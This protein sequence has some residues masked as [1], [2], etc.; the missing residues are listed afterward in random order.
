MKIKVGHREFELHPLL[1][2]SPEIS[3]VKKGPKGLRMNESFLDSWRCDPPARWEGFYHP[4]LIRHHMRTRHWPTEKALKHWKKQYKYNRYINSKFLEVSKLKSMR[5]FKTE[6]S[7]R[8]PN[9][10]SKVPWDHLTAD[11]REAHSFTFT[12]RE[13]HIRFYIDIP[14]LG[15]LIPHRLFIQY[16][17]AVTYTARV[18]GHCGDAREFRVGGGKTTT[19]E[20]TKPDSAKEVMDAWAE[21]VK[22]LKEDTKKIKPKMP[23]KDAVKPED[24]QK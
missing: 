21:G 9:W 5:E 10:T 13:R 4:M 16:P 3:H 14:E 6:L 2:E 19:I 7:K 8:F 12:M 18:T 22:K 17:V 15:Q 23:P 11:M 20:H 24:E 1:P